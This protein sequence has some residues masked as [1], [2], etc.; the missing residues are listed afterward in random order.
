MLTDRPGGAEEIQPTYK[1]IMNRLE[2]FL[3]DQRDGS[4]YFFYYAGHAAR[5]PPKGNAGEGRREECILPSDSKQLSG[6]SEHPD[7]NYYENGISDGVLK[8]HLV[9]HLSPKSYLVAIVDSCHSGTLLDLPHFRCNRVYTMKS[10]FRR[11]VRRIIEAYRRRGDRLFSLVASL[12]PMMSIH[13]QD[14]SAK[15]ICGGY[16]PR[17]AW[18]HNVICISSC[19]DDQRAYEAGDSSSMT[20]FIIKLLE[21]EPRPTLKRFMRQ[22]TAK[23]RALSKKLR[24]QWDGPEDFGPIAAPQVSSPEPLNMNALLII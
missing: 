23:F 2:R 1:N 13:R 6:D 21:K 4:R 12:A 7:E 10:L 24:K 17:T 15:Q 9:N 14:K 22:T 5:L 19:K 3:D 16:C 8:E 18:S 20:N 11:A